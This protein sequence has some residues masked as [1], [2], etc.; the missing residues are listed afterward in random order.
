MSYLITASV[1]CS[2]GFLLG[3]FWAAR[4]REEPDSEPALAL[5][6]E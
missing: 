5:V 4:D 3:V 2:I 6:R 1:F